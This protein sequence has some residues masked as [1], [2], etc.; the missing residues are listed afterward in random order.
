MLLLEHLFI[1]TIDTLLEQG[2]IFIFP[3]ETSH[4]RYSNIEF[5]TLTWSTQP[6][7]LAIVEN[8]LPSLT[9]CICMSVLRHIRVARSTK[10]ES[11]NTLA[12]YVGWTDASP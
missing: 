1:I 11:P 3:T 7:V 2:A 10:H 4:I 12:G 8:E 5:P 6:W 9:L